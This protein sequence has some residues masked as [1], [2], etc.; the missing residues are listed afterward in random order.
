MDCPQ[1]GSS[2]STNIVINLKA[3]DNVQFYSCRKCEARWWEHRGDT[4][5]LDEVLNLAARADS[6]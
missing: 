4:I 6:R 2:D 1:C 3:D 5:A